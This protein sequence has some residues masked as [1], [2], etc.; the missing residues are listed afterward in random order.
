M[1]LIEAVDP[2][3]KL[4]P[5][6]KAPEAPNALKIKLMWTGIVL[7]LFY[8]MSEIPLIGLSTVSS[9]QLEALQLLLASDIGTLISVGIG[10]IVLASIVLQLLVGAGIMQMD[11]TTSQGK[12]RFTGLQKLLAII[13]SFFEAAAFSGFGAE[14]VGFIHAMPGMYFVVVLQIA[15][16]SILLL[17]LDEVVSKHGIGSGIGMFIAAGV[18]STFFW[19]VFRPPTALDAGGRIFIFFQSLLAG[20][21][22][23]MIVAISPVI[24][25]II[26][27]L[28]VSFAEGM[29]INIPISMGK[30]GVGGRFPVKFLYVSNMPVILAVALFAN[31]QLWAQILGKIPFL[32]YLME[33]LSWATRSPRL[34]GNLSLFETIVLRGLSPLA[35]QEIFHAIVYMIVL[36]IVCVVFGK[37]WVELGGQGS[38]QMANQLEKAGMQIPGFRRDPRI[39]KRVLDRYIPTLTILGS[40]F[41]GLLAGFSDLTTASLVSGTGVLLTVGIVYKLYE[42]LAKAQLMDMHPLLKRFLG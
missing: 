8:I 32:G 13:L 4:I 33:G 18:A 2:L 29:H 9:Q 16:G 24:F 39:I 26:I 14:N 25:A 34:D 17:Y 21:F 22:S 10:P 41:V 3:L 15:L 27:F 6:V 37:F 12:A 20:Q 19:Q 30:A 11:L 35:V 42:E 7:I 1:A 36:L 31:V 5:E 38:T 28:V 40:L 23:A